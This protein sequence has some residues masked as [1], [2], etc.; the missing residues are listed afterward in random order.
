MPLE[1]ERK[2]LLKNDK[3]KSQAEGI[4]YKQGY[5]FDTKGRSARVRIVGNEAFL[6]IKA[7]RSGIVRDEYEYAIP[8]A[9][10]LEMMENHC[11]DE[12]IEKTRYKITYQNMVWEVDEFHGKNQG[13]VVAE[14]ELSDA[15]DNIEKPEWLGQEVSNDPKYFN[16][17]LVRNPYCTWKS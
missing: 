10:A 2:Y 17:N 4:L 1:I 13:L 16:T 14:I 11:N 5:L 8:L 9:D 15:S 3:W 6:T 12:I 7:S